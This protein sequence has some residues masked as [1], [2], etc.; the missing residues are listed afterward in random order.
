MSI[1]R[2]PRVTICVT[3]YKSKTYPY[4]KICMDSIKNLNYPADQLDVILCCH[5]ND[6]KQYK[7]EFGKDKV[8]VITPPEIGYS[9]ARAMNFCVENAQEGSKYFWI[10]NDDVIATKHSLFNLVESVG[11]HQMIA[12]PIAT[13][14]Q[15][16]QFQLVMGVTVNNEFVPFLKNFYRLPELEHMTKEIMDAGPIYPPGHIY[17]DFLCLFAGF[18]PKSVL[19]KVGKFEE[20]FRHA[21]PD[22]I[23]ISIRCQR[24]GIRCAFVLD[25]FVH[26][27]GGVSADNSVSVEDR[28]YN[29]KFFKAKHGLWPP[30]ITEESLAKLTEKDYQYAVQK[31]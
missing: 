26:H 14:D 19:D 9:N 2:L 6:Y 31:P 18:Y 16:R 29:A 22:D 21:G 3:T 15:G 12:N 10:L 20:G 17:T 23:D 24:M 1:S 4:L 11:D 30:G 27:F 25:S 7:I 28:I 8:N 5:Q 13:C